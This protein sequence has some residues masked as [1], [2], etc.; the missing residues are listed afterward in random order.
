MRQLA[1]AA[2]VS[3]IATAAVPGGIDQSGQPVTLLFHEGG[4]VEVGIGAIMPEIS[5]DGPPGLAT[6]NAYGDLTDLRGGIRQQITDRLAAALIIDQPYG[7]V[8]D[9][10]LA[11]PDGNFAYAGTNARPESVGITGLLRYTFTPRWSVHG[12][13]RATRFGATSTLGGQ[14]FGPVLDGYG[15]RGSDAWGLGY[16]VGGAYEIPEIALRVALTYGS[17]TDLTLDSTETHVLDPATG[18][19]GTVRSRLDMS[20]P[21][22]VN[23]D[24]Q[25][26][27]NPRTLLYG[28]VRWADW[29]GWNV[30]PEGFVALTGKPLVTFTDDT[31]TY[32]LGL[33]REFGARISGAV[34][35][36]HEAA[37][38][39]V[40]SPL[41]PYDGFTAV[42]VGVS[43]RTEAGLNIGAGVQMS[44]LGD[45]DVDTPLGVAQF[46]DNRS[47]SVGLR[48]GYAF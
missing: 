10:G 38:G 17:R 32:R 41:T 48:L 5:A 18:M 31:W 28:S 22:S 33:G 6:G 25:T 34:E 3:V 15:W 12:G 19:F 1:L 29:G 24:F 11:P 37:G 7:V 21:Q 9:Y 20:L 45:A 35:L 43:W 40:Q 27:I 4:Y 39:E 47:V 44:F 30:A 23:L 8:V 16:V 36:I 13:L 2:A 26:G 14:G 46:R 42:A